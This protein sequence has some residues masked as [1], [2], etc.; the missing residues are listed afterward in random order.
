MGQVMPWA[1][2]ALHC[3]QVGVALRHGVQVLVGQKEP[4]P[5]LCKAVCG[6]LVLSHTVLDLSKT[7]TLDSL[8]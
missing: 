6:C 8:L 3:R 4:L 5:H 1:L 2:W 7:Y